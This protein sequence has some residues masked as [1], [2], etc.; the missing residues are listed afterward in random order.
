MC[1]KDLEPQN[2]NA[3]QNNKAKKLQGSWYFVDT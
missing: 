2:H 1:Q 3:R